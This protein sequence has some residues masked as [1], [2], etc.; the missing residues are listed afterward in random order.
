M[1]KT[2][3][4]AAVLLVAAATP[5]FAQGVEVAQPD[6]ASPPREEGSLY[7]GAYEVTED[8]DLVYGGD[9]GFECEYLW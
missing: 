9:V 1:G 5:A 2:I 4:L 3:L 6:G 7:S 8:G